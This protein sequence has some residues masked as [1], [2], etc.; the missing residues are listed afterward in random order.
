MSSQPTYVDMMAAIDQGVHQQNYLLHTT[1]YYYLLLNNQVNFL[2][3]DNIFI[4][5]HFKVLVC[6]V[7]LIILKVFSFL[8]VLLKN[9]SGSLAAVSKQVEVF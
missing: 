8:S 6:F 2:Y 7:K 3:D 4:S 1:K 5:M 9:E